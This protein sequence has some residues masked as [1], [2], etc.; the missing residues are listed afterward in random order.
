[1]SSGTVQRRADAVCR[2][3]REWRLALV[4][5]GPQL[6]VAL[7]GPLV[8]GASTVR[9]AGTSRRSSLLLAAVDLVLEDAGTEASEIR[10]LIVSRGPG[11]FTG[12]RAGLA[13]AHGWS[14]GREAEVL[15]FDS[16]T[17]QAARCEAGV[18]EVYAAQPGRRG[19]VF[20]RR[21]GLDEHSAPEPIGEIE[22]ARVAEL[23][24][25]LPVVGAESLELG[26]ARRV[27]TRCGAAEALLLLAEL[28]SSQPVEPVYVDPP[29][30][31]G[32]GGAP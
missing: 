29:P 11:S 13:S 5:C 22:V 25:D 26:F 9:L 12:V 15:A 27:P 18:G 1:M 21:F 14:V 28:T 24:E 19:E 31:Q 20:L 23:A 8:R 2:A 4:T 7:A 10:Q 16:L 30:I 17:M 32:S 6:E 3:P